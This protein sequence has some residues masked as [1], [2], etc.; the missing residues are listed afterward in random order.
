M[1]FLRVKVDY[2]DFRVS[3]TE[4]AWIELTPAQFFHANLS[5]PW[6][7]TYE[8]EMF[9][10][11]SQQNLNYVYLPPMLQRPWLTRIDS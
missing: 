9:H 6:W 4:V 3:A 11:Y 2:L 1:I 8:S 7:Q 10:L 5:Y